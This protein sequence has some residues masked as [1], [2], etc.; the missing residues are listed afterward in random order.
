MDLRAGNMTS[1]AIR[2]MMERGINP[3]QAEILRNRAVHGGGAVG[4][5]EFDGVVGEMGSEPEEIRALREGMHVRFISVQRLNYESEEFSNGP[6]RRD[7]ASAISR[8]AE[9]VA[10]EIDLA[11]VLYATKTREQSRSFV[12]RA[13]EAMEAGARKDDL[14]DLTEIVARIRTQESEYQRLGI[15]ETGSTPEIRARMDTTYAP[16][17]LTYYRALSSGHLIE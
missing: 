14:E 16:L 5:Y 7:Q 9:L 12:E 17:V 13:L 11:Q 3:K 4:I 15:V 6:R 2:L 10:K 1:H 8:I